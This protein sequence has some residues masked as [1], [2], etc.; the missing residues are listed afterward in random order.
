MATGYSSMT[1]SAIPPKQ[2]RRNL[3][4]QSACGLVSGKRSEELQDDTSSLGLAHQSV[5]PDRAVAPSSH[6]PPFR[7]PPAHSPAPADPGSMH[8]P[9][10]VKTSDTRRR[11]TQA[12]TYEPYEEAD[13]Q[14]YGYR[15]FLHDGLR[16]STKTVQEE[17]TSS[18]G[19]RP[20]VGKTKRGIAGRYFVTRPGPSKR[21]PG[22]RGSAIA[23]RAAFQIAAG[24]LAGTSGSGIHATVERSKYVRQAM[25]LYEAQ[26]YEPQKAAHLQP[27]GSR[28]F[29]H[30]ELC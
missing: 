1:D 16:H 22:P 2:C 18:V 15:I 6:A 4:R 8:R 26:T 7:L 11:H 20:R 19:L 10:V 9:S 17:F 28:I 27:H 13:L 24:A 5:F 25:A 23:Q 30:D 29:L 21:L 3:L 12:K 14:P